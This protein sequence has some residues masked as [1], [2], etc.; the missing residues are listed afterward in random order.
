MC[1][2]N[3]LRIPV[4]IATIGALLA[5]AA[6]G[7]DSGDSDDAISTADDD[8]TDDET[9]DDDIA[10]DDDTADDDTSDD[11]SGDDD[12]RIPWDAPID[13][14]KC[15]AIGNEGCITQIT[16]GKTGWTGIDSAFA[17]DGTAYLAAAEGWEVA[18]FSLAPGADEWRST[19]VDHTG[20]DPRLEIGED[21]T[22]HLLYGDIYNHLL[23]YAHFDGEEWEREIIDWTGRPAFT[24]H[25]PESGLDPYLRQ[26]ADLALAPDG[27]PHISYLHHVRPD[28]WHVEPVGPEWRKTLVQPYTRDHGLT[29]YF[30]GEPSLR[31]DPEGNPHLVHLAATSFPGATPLLIPGFM[32][33]NIVDPL[34]PNEALLTDAGG[35]RPS[36]QIDSRGKVYIFS[37]FYTETA[38]TRP[39]LLTLSRKKWSVEYFAGERRSF[40]DLNSAIDENDKFHVVVSDP[41]NSG[42]LGYGT[43]Q[44]G[45]WVFE[46]EVGTATDPALTSIARSEDGALLLA[47]YHEWDSLLEVVM[48]EGKGPWTPTVLSN[49]DFSPVAVFPQNGDAGAVVYSG[50]D[51]RYLSLA[52]DGLAEYGLPENFAPVTRDD[53]SVFLDADQRLELLLRTAENGLEIHRRTQDGWVAESLLDGPVTGACGVADSSGHTHIAARIGESES[54]ALW[55]LTDASGAW[56]KQLVTSGD[57][58]A[59][60]RV[61]RDDDGGIYLGWRNSEG[62]WLSRLSG[63]QWTHENILPSSYGEVATLALQVQDPV[64]TSVLYYDK[65]PGA[66]LLA[67]PAQSGWDV[68]TI[69]ANDM[70]THVDPSAVALPNGGFL[71]NYGSPDLRITTLV[72]GGDGRTVQECRLDGFSEYSSAQSFVAGDDV[73]IAYGTGGAVQLYRSTLDKICTA[74]RPPLDA[75]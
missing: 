26:H 63:E 24:Y 10:A 50:G 46:S 35:Y 2:G 7:A 68:Q 64:H 40:Y 65:S 8:T 33:S 4:Y 58:A 70:I 22:I 28:V 44:G 72:L 3:I 30:G 9:T 27:T 15:F 69:R 37:N 53:C 56:N 45:D 31:V 61:A 54:A 67:L 43:N 19:I 17:P 74:E 48:R 39:Q 6:C 66:L 52:A 73:L 13:R 20:I 57:V 21:G 16:P 55:Y 14:H 25:L 71:I 59:P 49:G 29:F 36:L 11:D 23:V 34:K 60:V 38:A 12:S 42:R 62:T 18:L 41:K 47:G 51:Y 1:M 75:P 5:I 32:Y